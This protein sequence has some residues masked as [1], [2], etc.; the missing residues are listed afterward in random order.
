MPN[1]TTIPEKKPT[2]LA[3]DDNP[4]VAELLYEIL[5]RTGNYNVHIVTSGAEALEKIEEITPDLVLL[6]ILMPEMNGYETCQHLRKKEKTREIPIL[7][8]SAISE[9]S[10]KIKAYE[11]GAYDF[12]HKPVDPKSLI[13]R[14]E[15]YLKLKKAQDELKASQA[16]LEEKV[17]QSTIQL[18]EA[19]EELRLRNQQLRGLTQTLIVNNRTLN[20][21]I[22]QLQEKTMALKNSESL[23]QTIFDSAS[24]GIVLYNPQ[25]EIIQFNP[26]FV[27][28]IGYPPDELRGIHFE[29][30]TF[31]EDLGN[32]LLSYHRLNTKLLNEYTLEKR[33]VRKNGDIIWGRNNV[34]S[35]LSDDTT[36]FSISIIENIDAQKRAQL[37]LEE[38]QKKLEAIYDHIPLPAMV[39]DNNLIVVNTNPAAAFL[40]RH[41]YNKPEYLGPG[42]VL[43]CVNAINYRTCGVGPACTMCPLNS[44]IK[45]TFIDH[46]KIEKAEI[47]LKIL[48]DKT[49]S[50]RFFLV[51]TVP[52]QLNIHDY[53]L[54]ILDDITNRKEAELAIIESEENFRT[55]FNS[56]LDA[57]GIADFNDRIVDVNDAMCK[58]IGIDK[59]SL[60]GQDVNIIAYPDRYDTLNTLLYRVKLGEKLVHEA[61]LKTPR[62]SMPVECSVSQLTINH[63]KYV[64]G[65]FRDITYRKQAE[66]QMIKAIVEAEEKRREHFAQ[67]L[68][69]GIGPILSTIKLYLQWMT[70][71]N[72]RMPLPELI[73]KTEETVDIAHKTV[74]EI[75]FNL[76]PHILQNFGL[77]SAL[78]TFIDRIG[79]L[80]PVPITFSTNLE[81]RIPDIIETILYRIITEAI[82]NTIKYASAHKI[83]LSLKHTGY[84]ILLIYEDD[85]IGFDVEKTLASKNGMGLIN[86]QSR[87]RSVG[88][89]M[90]IESKK[91][92]GCRLTV[93]VSS[94][95]HT[96]YE[97]VI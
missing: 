33:Y 50:E 54:I 36:I 18:S 42:D 77:V 69:D 87:I 46:V 16:E 37:S 82:N 70:L 26:A 75:S 83:N 27:D 85:G 52:Y 55:I 3:I 35:I 2:I 1:N 53:L 32:E 31:T 15:V 22:D 34:T 39:L 14:I 41:N 29:S 95:P 40:T 11:A 62:G 30:I 58:F 63:N 28:F 80:Y 93:E 97:F 10:E 17:K 19:N 71:P 57:I 13:T 5:S 6:D 89:N 7:F 66:Q 88:G 61:M 78:K 81:Q 56:T 20:E 24:V 4:E 43:C 59:Q 48:I 51:S 86:M 49:I 65:V 60:I 25:G 21:T 94:N 76:N 92:E 44:I 74:R 84:Q 96:N 9:H 23:M 12:I 67:E 45:K 79:E 64:L 68:H 73:R 38:S 47:K 72:L 90:R 91:N 8:L